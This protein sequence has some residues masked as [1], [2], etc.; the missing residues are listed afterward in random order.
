M[1]L[2]GRGT[3]TA[4][5]RALI[6]QNTFSPPISL[7][8]HF[9]STKNKKPLDTKLNFSLSSD[10]DDDQD[11]N[12]HMTKRPLPPPYDPFSKKPAIQEPKD[13]KDL[14]EIFHNM[15]NG[16]GLFN[17][18]VKMFDALSKEGLTHEA[19]ELLGQIKD[20]GHMPD[21]VAHT[22]IL[23]AYADA[24]QPK[25]ALKVYMRM[26]ACGVSPNA[27]TYAVLVKGLASDGKYA[28]EASKYMLEMMDKGMRPNAETYTSLFE[29]LVREERLHEAARLLEQMKEKGFVPD[30]KA[31][32]QALSAKR[33]PVF[34]IL[35]NLLFGS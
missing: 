18:A 6:F 8:R 35:I 13:P 17:H 20:K 3:I 29:R 9:C 12:T 22:A 10:S 21:V 14:Q 23:E 31:V 1:A 24:A 27:Y 5:R 15:R 28:K 26:L 19:L 11:S 7:D 30:H 25:E 16:D 32:H 2:C 34:R 4:I 33:G